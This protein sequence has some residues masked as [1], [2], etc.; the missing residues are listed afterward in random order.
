[1][2]ITLDALRMDLGHLADHEVVVF[3]SYA[4]GASTPRSD[5]DVAILTRCRERSVNEETWWR[6]LGT[7]P[8]AYDLRV[9]ELLPIHIQVEIARHHIVVFGDAR[10]IANY[11]HPVHRRWGDVRHRY[12]KPLPTRERLSRLAGAASRRT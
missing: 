12:H 11:F 10:E 3:G 7:A 1:M 6:L 9:F 4:T 2:T 8:D 5:V